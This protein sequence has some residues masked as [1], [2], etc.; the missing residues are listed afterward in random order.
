[1]YNGNGRLYEFGGFTLNS[2]SETLWREGELVP[3]SP[4]AVKLL[5]LLVERDG[6]LVTKQEIFDSVWGDTFVTDGVLT[7]NIYTLR[8]KLGTGADGKQLIETVPRRGYRFSGRVKSSSAESG[9]RTPV[10]AG[11]Q[12]VSIVSPAYMAAPETSTSGFTRKRLA[13]F[14]LAALL[15]VS[16][17]ASVSFWTVRYKIGA[18]VPIGI[19]AAPIEQLRLQP[20]TDS[21]D[22]IYPTISPNGELLAYI[23]HGD[24][25]T[26][27][28]IRQIA[29]GSSVQILPP[30]E[31]GYRSLAFTPDGSYIYFREQEESGPLYRVAVLGGAP[32]RMPPTVSGDFAVSPDGSA[33]A[34]VRSDRSRSVESLVVASLDGGSEREIISTP[35]ARGLTGLPA[36][37]PNGK[38][39]AIGKRADDG[40]SVGLV[41]VDIELGTE[42]S[43]QTRP[44][45]NVAAILWMPE[46]DSLVFSARAT[47]EPKPQLWIFDTKDKSVRRLTNDLEG[48]FWLSRSADGKVLVTRQQRIDARVWLADE[49]IAADARAITDGGRSLDGYSGLTIGPDGRIVYTVRSDN[50]NDLFTIAGGRSEPFRLTSDSGRENTRPQFTPDGRYLIFSSDRS[51]TRQIWRMDAEGGGQQQLTLDDGG[52]TS[53]D[54]PAVPHTGSDVYFIRRSGERASVWKIPVS[55]G[56]P[57]P[58]YAPDSSVSGPL[59]VSPNAKWLAV[60]LSAK[61]GNSASR[62]AV[63]PVDGAADARFF[64]IEMRRPVIR[65]FSDSEFDYAAGPGDASVIMRQN[66]NGASPVKVMEFP[67]RVYN[68][69]WSRDGRDLVVSRGALRG[70]AILITNLR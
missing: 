14:A 55:G 48:Y 46:G 9:T 26:S 54:W 17:V 43:L 59:S 44:W 68:F 24:T 58:V 53:S 28:W 20:I 37:S 8:N 6:E 52:R 32:V 51:G 38:E 33:I 18:N 49:G 57:S 62:V 35:P 2:G 39:I 40:N 1:M 36:W 45:R 61:V 12:G 66:I 69:A 23:R 29:T 30:S 22:V 41:A 56:E 27:V 65:W 11:S 64:D 34:F 5:L 21:G 50:A 31:K 7:Q 13:F 60:S 15:A 67:D 3:V 19:V 47:D 70:D 25:D 63:V 42:T 10:P 16:A 4:K